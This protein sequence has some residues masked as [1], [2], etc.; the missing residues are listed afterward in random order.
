[1]WY[2]NIFVL[3]LSMQE[4]SVLTFSLYFSQRCFYK[5]TLKSRRQPTS[6]PSSHLSVLQGSLYRWVCSHCLRNGPSQT[7]WLR[8]RNWL[9]FSV[10]IIS[11][12]KS[13][14]E[15]TLSLR[16]H[17]IFVLKW[18]PG[19]APSY[20]NVCV[21]CWWL[22]ELW[23][24]YLQNRIFQPVRRL[25]EVVLITPRRAQ[26]ESYRVKSRLSQT[27]NVPLQWERSVSDD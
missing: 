26:E 17:W 13:K 18:R 27:Q 12:S 23:L 4:E 15:M 5:S 19:R 25:A 16:M 1:M 24:L 22:Q 7:Y 21:L 2:S 8:S 6:T 3:K 20:L 9:R 11:Q 10:Y 14:V